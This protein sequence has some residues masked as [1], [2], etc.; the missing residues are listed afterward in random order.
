MNPFLDQMI[1][2]EVI[3]RALKGSERTAKQL[4][5]LAARYLRKNKPMPGPLREYVAERLE[6]EGRKR[7]R[8]ACEHKDPESI[9][10]IV[11]QRR[12]HIESLDKLKKAGEDLLKNNILSPFQQ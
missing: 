5:K 3:D 11:R 8:S 10:R 2:L 9:M 1:L 12:Q 7:G 6:K 4:D